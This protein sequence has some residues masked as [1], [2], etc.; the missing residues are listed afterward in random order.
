[1]GFINILYANTYYTYL[2]VLVLAAAVVVV[3]SLSYI[4]MQQIYKVYFFDAINVNFFFF[5]LLIN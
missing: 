2:C 3:S 5:G 4:G 1:M